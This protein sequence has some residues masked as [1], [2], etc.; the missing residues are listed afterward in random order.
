MSAPTR[1]RSGVT[2]ADNALEFAPARCYIWR[3]T[4]HRGEELRITGPILN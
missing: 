4:A 3:M 2:L 1:R